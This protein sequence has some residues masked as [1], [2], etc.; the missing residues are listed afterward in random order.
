MSEPD[1]LIYTSA[2]ILAD[3]SS[4]GFIPPSQNPEQ[5]NTPSELGGLDTKEDY[6]AMY[7][8]RRWPS[9]D[10]SSSRSILAPPS[11]VFPSSSGGGSDR[12]TRSERGDG[13]ETVAASEDAA[14]LRQR[15]DAIEQVV[16]SIQE[17]RNP[18]DSAEVPPP[19]YAH[20][21]QK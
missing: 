8:S 14:K 13:T 21:V 2:P 1:P 11:S 19:S 18:E 9:Y 20:S 3:Q 17:R 10:E 6:L 15:L 12:P 16:A 7:N 4:S 5:S